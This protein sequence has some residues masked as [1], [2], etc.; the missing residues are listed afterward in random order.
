L[1][2]FGDPKVVALCDAIERKDLA[3]ID[4]LVAEGADVTAKSCVTHMT[5]LLYS[6][7][8]GEAVFKR[9]LE[10]GADPNVVFGHSFGTRGAIRPGDS[11]M[12][13]CAKSE[14]PNHLRLA[15]EHGGD[16]NL[17]DDRGETPIFHAIMKG[18]EEHLRL[19]IKS[20]ADLE[21]KDNY[22][23]T[24]LLCA[25]GW[26]AYKYALILIEAGADCRASGRKGGDIVLRLAD[27]GWRREHMGPEE[28]RDYDKLVSI[29]EER[30]ADFDAAR[31]ELELCAKEGKQAFA[32]NYRRRLMQHRQKERRMNPAW[33]K[34]GG[35]REASSKP[36][37]DPE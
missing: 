6:F 24:P 36:P 21:H 18:R 2:Y 4:R 12:T 27:R 17:A 1:S 7:P 10:H 11:I 31:R 33:W 28:G 25:A 8:S 20:G 22:G 23:R 16:P 30:G 29:L 5:P 19:L 26:G 13:M 32:S 14:F 15:L 35:R 9:L 34:A 37:G 3:E